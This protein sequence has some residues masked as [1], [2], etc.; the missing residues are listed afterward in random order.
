MS[1]IT[2]HP[3]EGVNPTLGLCFWCGSEDGTIGLLG[4]NKGR[5]AE[6][7]SIISLEPC[8]QCRRNM[9]LGITVI[10]ATKYQKE[11]WQPEVAPGVF[12]TGRWCVAKREAHFWESIMEPLRSQIMKTGKCV[13]EPD[14]YEAFG[15]D[16]VEPELPKEPT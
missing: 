11:R 10:E 12:P 7:K 6:R 8:P 3:T 5:K 16:K 1:R 13:L 15:F 14:L 4:Y 9:A 2:L